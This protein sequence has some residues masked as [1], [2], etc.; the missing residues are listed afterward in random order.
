M[1]KAQRVA[2]W[3]NGVALFAT[4][5]MPA[6]SLAQA[7]PPAHPGSDPLVARHSFYLPM[8]D[9]VRLAVNVYRPAEHGKP[10]ATREPVVF[11]FTPYRARYFEGGKLVDLIDS[12]EFGLR[13]LVHDGYV[14]ATADVRGKGASF[15]H[16]RGFLDQ[17]EAKDGAEIVQWLAK[18]PY[19]TGKVGMIG[20]SYLGG[21][22]MLVAGARPPA[23]KAVFAAA[24]DWDKY[25]FVRRGG[26][27][28]QFNT[29]PDDPPSV[30][31]T[32]VPVD[33]DP[34]GK[35]LKE[36]VAQHA[37]NTPMAALWY[38]MPYRDSMSKYTGTKFWEEVGPYTHAADLKKPGLAWYLWSNWTDEPTEQIIRAAANLPAKMI[39][40][41]GMHCVPPK[42][43][44]IN[45][46]QKRFFDHYLKG[47]QN[48]IDKEPKYTWW[49]ENGAGGDL[50]RSNTLPGQ[51]VQRVSLFLGMPTGT[52]T[53][54]TLT[55]AAPAATSVTYAIDYDVADDA[56]F[57]FWPKSPDAHALT[58]TTPP[59]A[60]PA[61]VEGYPVVTIR[62]AADAADADVFAYLEDVTPDGAA[63]VLAMGRLAGSHR[64][65][66]TAPYNNLD[67]PYHSGL[68]KDVSPLTPGTPVTL[69][70]ALSP[71]SYTVQS[72]H[73]L[74]VA[75]AGADPR[76][77]NLAEIKDHLARHLTL[78][79]G[80]AS[81]IAIP[82]I[83][84]V[85][86]VTPAQ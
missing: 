58:F 68:E 40:G 22:A 24:T 11:A 36:A 31:L 17:T 15:G 61:T 4:L 14:V 69:R 2:R 21:S 1:A 7:T 66:G 47:I 70:F 6:A 49:R 9:G 57:T 79:G 13:D 18:Q 35:L 32:S 75:I 85:R 60:M 51:G 80:T 8:R 27:T 42:Q 43:F 41:P 63:T 81:S 59:L 34:D 67:L 62:L 20:C 72:G 5:A 78:T 46:V 39:I 45:A 52:E 33:A 19:T 53:P 76:Q 12:P 64:K 83:T 86:F 77:R 65:P 10:V 28:A 82:F 3:A 26:I 16:R 56:Y 44:N 71:R 50:I 48:G 30:G 84:P 74:R 54:G 37:E 29:R 55:P 73:R 25:T 23:L 38:G